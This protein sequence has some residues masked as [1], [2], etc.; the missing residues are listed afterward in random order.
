MKTN[1]SRKTAII[2]SIIFIAFALGF[3]WLSKDNNVLSTENN[4]AVHSE[5]LVQVEKE[6]PIIATVK[7][8]SPETY[9]NF[10][11]LI[12]QYDPNNEDL[13][14]QL[15]DQVVGNVMKLVLERIEYASD[16]SVINFTSKANDYLKVL[17][18]EDPT[19]KTCF[20]SIFP[21][22][23]ETAE[24]ILPKKNQAVLL[25][26]IQVTNELLISSESGIKQTLMSPTEYTEML[27]KLAGELSIKYGE[28]AAILSDLN[29]WKK[30][31]ALACRVSINF[32]DEILSL[33][34]NA[35]KAALLR[36]LFS[37]TNN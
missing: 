22:L 27:T 35:Q 21:Q 16:D 34:D 33:P 30:T 26:Q 32:Y 3:Y 36:S 5:A 14:R 24:F 25:K 11:H 18:E 20:Y 19:G 23:R 7:K 29:A 13:R 28:D 6:L 37:S 17:L 4:S 8:I 2:V 31:P 10:E 12:T 15:F 1:S 9:Q